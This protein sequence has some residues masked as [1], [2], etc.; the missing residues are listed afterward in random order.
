MSAELPATFTPAQAEATGILR[1]RLWELQRDG[2][3]ERIARGLYRSTD[4]QLADIDLLEIAI[5]SSAGTLCLLSALAQHDLTDEIPP[6]HDI[7]VPRGAWQ[8]VVQAPVSWHHFDRA[9]VTVGR[10]ELPI[11]LSDQHRPV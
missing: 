11:E 8:P 3:V 10:D 6:A 5:K 7:A 2:S 1:H 4:A 9:T